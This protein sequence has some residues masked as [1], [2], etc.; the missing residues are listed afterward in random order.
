MPPT[1]NLMDEPSD[2]FSTARRPTGSDL[3]GSTNPAP[4]GLPNPSDIFNAPSRLVGSG[5]ASDI[6]NEASRMAG[7]ESDLFGG[8]PGMPFDRGSSISDTESKK[9]E[10]VDFDRMM[11]SPPVEQTNTGQIEFDMPLNVGSAEVTGSAQ[12]VDIPE[13]LEDSSLRTQPSL[14]KSPIPG[15]SLPAKIEGFED[16]YP[17][18]SETDREAS[19]SNLFGDPGLLEID[20]GGDA[21]DGIDVSGVDL[22]EPMDMPE[23]NLSGTRSSIF[24]K[25]RGELRPAED[26]GGRVDF[27]Q[28]PIMGSSDERTESMLFLDDVESGPPSGIFSRGLTGETDTNDVLGRVNFEVPGTTN[29]PS[30]RLPYQDSGSLDWSKSNGSDSDATKMAAGYGGRGPDS[31]PSSELDL[32]ALNTSEEATQRT[33]IDE[34]SVFSAAEIDLDEFAP[35]ASQPSHGDDDLLAATPHIRGGGGTSS[36]PSAVSVASGGIALGRKGSRPSI[37]LEDAEPARPGRSWLLPAV[38]LVLGGSLGAGAMFFAGGSSTTPKTNMGTAAIVR[39]NPDA[40]SAGPAAITPPNPA[41]AAKLIAANPKTAIALFTGDDPVDKAHRGQARWMARVREVAGANQKLA[42]DD[43]ELQQATEEL[44]GV[45]DAAA[46]LKTPSEQQAGL[47]AGLHLGLIQEA[48]GKPDD[49]IAAY[50]LAASKLPKMYQRIFDS[51]IE[52]VGL[53]KKGADGAPVKQYSQALP[54]PMVTDL[55]EAVNLLQFA[56]VQQLDDEPGF[57][58]WEAISH[59][60]KWNVVGSFDKAIA[61]INKAKQAHETRRKAQVGLG[62]NPLSDPSEQIFLRVCEELR[63]YWTFK[64]QLYD[65]PT[66]MALARS[67]GTRGMLDELLKAK[68]A[69]DS[70]SGVATTPKLDPKMVDELNTAKRQV[71]MLTIAEKAVRLERDAADEKVKTTF[72]DLKKVTKDLQETAEMADKMRMNLKTAESKLKSADEGIDAVL[73]KMKDAKL[74]DA[75]L[76]RAAMLAALPEALKKAVVVTNK[77][78]ALAELTDKLTTLQAAAKVEKDEA[79]KKLAEA[80]TQYAT[81]KETATKT[82]A[83]LQDQLKTADTKVAAEVKKATEASAA[84]IARLEKERDADRLAQESKLR[85]QAD[86]FALQIAAVRSGVNVVL[87]DVER[88]NSDRAK[89]EYGNGVDAYFAGRFGEAE[90]ALTQSVKDDAADARAW[91]FLGLAK[92]QQGRSSEAEKD[93]RT[94]ASWEARMKPT[95]RVI[96]DALVRVQGPIRDALEVFRP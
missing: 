77:D 30:G 49:A 41:D 12:L 16:D 4:T 10:R 94:G 8:F 42:A 18:F 57:H 40:G 63:F 76:D 17:D 15:T 20:L 62:L 74:V 43:A 56:A 88:A 26:L 83:S 46:D 68:K 66:G 34:E 38:G 13:S 52:R 31:N 64:K 55:G 22:M 59:S 84:T 45:L 27:E 37:T 71:E 32:D 92:A 28:I 7:A 21:D 69:L 33:K 82:I 60:A 50:R 67:G 91:Y 51:A 35:A 89:R 36:R 65:D 93:Y 78:S 61:A 9:T 90:I 19:G 86:Q 75:K 70:G 23:T 81:A 47:R 85:Q 73:E 80:E 6:F 29:P 87:T 53:M 58:F 95:R 39:P 14:P 79:A 2:I 54:L 96:G 72:S 11:A 3:F 48:L 5:G 1:R 24:T 44:K 25:P